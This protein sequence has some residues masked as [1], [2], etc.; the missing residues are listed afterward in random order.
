MKIAFDNQIFN[1]QQYGG[2][3]RYLAHLA[4]EFYQ[5]N[6]EIKIFAGLNE[7]YYL[8]NLP[9]KIVDGKYIKFLP[10]TQRIAN[11][12][13]NLYITNKIKAWQPQ[14]I[15]KTYYN[16][17][18]FDYPT[19]V[20]VHDMI[21]ELFADSFPL[22]DKTSNIKKIAVDNADHIITVS[23]STK[24]DLMTLL[25]I[26]E[27]K[28]TVVHHGY[29]YFPYEKINNDLL[30]PFHQ[31]PY[32]FYVGQRGGYKNF[33]KLLQAYATMPLRQDFNLIAFGG[34]T[35]NSQELELL[36]KLNLSGGQVKQMSG[37]D[38]LLGYLYENAIAF[39]YPSLYEGFGMPP[40]EAMA[41]N[42]P[43]ICSNTSSIPEV[44]GDSAVY[45]DPNNL[46]DMQYKIETVI[47]DKVLQEDL[48]ARG[49]QR[50]QQFSWQKC[51][52]ETLRVYQKII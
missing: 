21:H 32:I 8:Q 18:K 37:D 5:L 24:K 13:N 34:G 35:F 28:I 22:K 51:A 27:E 38:T 11:I 1:Q 20:T 50:I 14:V 2:I 36:K 46:D 48:Q 33:T 31:K 52:E 10:K 12:Y 9:Q 4:E 17:K 3:S 47:Q 40:L 39:V 16:D 42:C 19:V 30:E 23:H 45:F 49:Q 26:S 41:H 29:D 6:H 44:V 7:N 25:N 43:V 15:H